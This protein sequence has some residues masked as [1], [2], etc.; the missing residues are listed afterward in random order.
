MQLQNIIILQNKVDL[1]KEEAAKLQHDQI[2]AF[3]EGTVAGKAP[4]IPISAQLGYNIDKVCKAIVTKVSEGPLCLLLAL[5][6]DF[7][8]APYDDP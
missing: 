8:S 6:L 4:I 5:V 7:F 2:Q 1:V 3:V